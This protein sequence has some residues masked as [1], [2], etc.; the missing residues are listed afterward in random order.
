M[1]RWHSVIV[2]NDTP[3][4]VKHNPFAILS[5]L[6]AATFEFEG[7]SPSGLKDTTPAYRFNKSNR[8][9]FICYAS[10]TNSLSLPQVAKT[11]FVSCSSPQTSINFILSAHFDMKIFPKA[12]ILAEGFCEYFPLNFKCLY[13]WNTRNNLLFRTCSTSTTPYCKG[14]RPRT[15]LENASYIQTKQI[16]NRNTQITKHNIHKSEVKT[17][18]ARVQFHWK[19]KTRRKS[20]LVHPQACT[21]Q[22]TLEAHSAFVWRSTQCINANWMSDVLTL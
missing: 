2:T 6:A 3:S 18:S 5:A 8:D 20:H 22:K 11:F 10:T 1:W 15:L 21:I 17:C 19:S 14:T 4:L 12:E 16:E 9:G 7:Y 13:S